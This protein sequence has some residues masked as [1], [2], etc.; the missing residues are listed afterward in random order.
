MNAINTKADALIDGQL[1]LE[2]RADRVATLSL[3]LST[4]MDTERQTLD[5]RGGLAAT[6]GSYGQLV[7]RKQQLLL[8]YQ[9]AVKALLGQGR[10]ALATLPTPLRAQLRNAGLT[11]DAA[12]RAS[13][14][15]LALAA[16]ATGRVLQVIMESVR[17]EANAHVTPGYQPNQFAFYKNQFASSSNPAL[18][19]AKA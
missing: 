4:L 14:E 1:E 6:A 8:D 7:Q 2:R 9:T 16:A 12:A 10:D 15:N 18:V 13:A 11:L 17:R 5:Q 19:A 3:Q